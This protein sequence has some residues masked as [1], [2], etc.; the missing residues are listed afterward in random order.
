[1][2]SLGCQPRWTAVFTSE[3]L[4]IVQLSAPTQS[5][6][7]SDGVGSRDHVVRFLGTGILGLLPS[8]HQF[9]E[10][11]R[12]ACFVRAQNTQ[13]SLCCKGAQGDMVAISQNG[14][15]DESEDSVEG[16]VLER[17]KR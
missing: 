9:N 7:R 2:L 6:V 13:R 14:P 17:A 10:V 15:L 8:H 5:K 3:H 12:D 11:R 4:H 1:M 16:V